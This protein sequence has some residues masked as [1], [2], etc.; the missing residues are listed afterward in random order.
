MV[1]KRR[2]RGQERDLNCKQ[3]ERKNNGEYKEI[4]VITFRTVVEDMFHVSC[5][6]GDR[7]G[8]RTAIPPEAS[9]HVEIILI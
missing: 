3:Q 9:H 5:F 8:E 4:T 1:G 6:M 2:Q 7:I